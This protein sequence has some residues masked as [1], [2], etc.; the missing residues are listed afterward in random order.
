M[1]VLAAMIQPPGVH[2]VAP[3]AEGCLAEPTA[4]PRWVTLHRL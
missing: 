3:A 2:I 1:S 4:D